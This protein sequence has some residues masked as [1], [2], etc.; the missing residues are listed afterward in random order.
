VAHAKRLGPARTVEV[1]NT[2][3]RAFDELADRW[4]VEKIKTIGDSYMAAAGLPV[5]APDHAERLAGMALAMIDTARRIARDVEVP[6]ALRIGIASGPVLAGVIG[7]KRLVYDVW[8]DTVNLAAR[9]EQTGEA[10][11]IQ[12]APETQ[13]RLKERFVLEERGTIEVRGKGPMR[14]WFL[15]GR[16]AA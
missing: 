5:A 13:T 7:A 2:I 11:K 12:V 1:L 14:T 6:F 10:G 9:M 15:V 4:G 16:R 3:M 8:G